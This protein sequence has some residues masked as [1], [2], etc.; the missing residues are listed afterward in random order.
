MVAASTDRERERDR[1]FIPRN[2]ESFDVPAGRQAHEQ[3]LAD[4]NP[5][6]D[7][8]IQ[9][10]PVALHSQI[11]PH[12]Q[13]VPVS[14]ENV[15]STICD[16]ALPSA[17]SPME[18]QHLKI[19]EHSFQSAV[20][21]DISA[22]NSVLTSATGQNDK[23]EKPRFNQSEGRIYLGRVDWN[24]SKSDLVNFCQKYVWFS[25]SCFHFDMLLKVRRGY[26]R[27]HSIR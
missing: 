6:V 20:R 14:R 7:P 21:D 17:I 1:V 8:S 25:V 2:R 12:S 3:P 23:I 10:Q 24:T 4:R 18:Q 15:S 22:S 27:V 5:R 26:R 11:R 13:Q 16:R 9:H 19:E